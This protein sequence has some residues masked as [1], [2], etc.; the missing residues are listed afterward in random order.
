MGSGQFA[1]Q[2]FA[3]AAYQGHLQYV[4]TNYNTIDITPSPIVTNS[5]CYSLT[6]GYD[7]TG[8]EGYGAYEFLGGPAY[9]IN[10][11]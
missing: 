3:E 5:S 2:D 8:T 1:S 7:N 4:D 9:G 10:C 6:S 11:Q